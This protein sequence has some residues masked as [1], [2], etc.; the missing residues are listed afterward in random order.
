MGFLAAFKT[1]WSDDNAFAFGSVGLGFNFRARQIGQ[2]CQPLV[3]DTTFRKELCWP[4]AQRRGDE[5]R[6]FVT[7][8]SVIHKVQ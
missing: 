1:Y 7:P 3:S 2:N 8:F 6:L 4:E 5:P